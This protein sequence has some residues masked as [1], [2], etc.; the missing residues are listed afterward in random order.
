MRPISAP[1]AR[2]PPSRLGRLLLEGGHRR[3]IGTRRQVRHR[4][5]LERLRRAQRTDA[6][7]RHHHQLGRVAPGRHQGPSRLHPRET[8][9][10]AG[11]L[12]RVRD[13]AAQ[14]PA[15]P[16]Q[17]CLGRPLDPPHLAP[18][19]VRHDQQHLRV[20]LQR[21]GPQPVEAG[22]GRVGS[23]LAQ[24]LLA[25]LPR[26]ARGGRRLAQEVGEEGAVGRVRGG[27][28]VGAEL[29]AP[30][31]LSRLR[32]ARTT[33]RRGPGRA[34]PLPRA[35]P[36]PLAERR[37]VVEHVDASAEGGAHQVV[38]APVQLHVAERDRRQ[39]PQLEP[40]GAPVGTEV[41]AELGA[42]RRTGRA[43]RDPAGAPRRSSPGGRSP[44]IERQVR[45]RSVLSKT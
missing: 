36:A 10:P 12:H 8:G 31:S 32:R 24:R 5:H 22:E 26:L 39:A 20:R 2:D 15:H 16:V 30:R 25:G 38:V 28:V 27:E 29:R 11:Q 14:V 18:G 43:E 40:V 3:R 44:A 34:H 13:R 21:F 37:V 23:L 7:R 35:P 33:R 6:A 17:P 45:P 41:E 9:R 19:G 4:L 1:A 42:E